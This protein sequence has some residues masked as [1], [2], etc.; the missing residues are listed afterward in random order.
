MYGTYIS[1]VL[2][3]FDEITKLFAIE[4]ELRIIRRRELLP[5]PTISPN[6]S[7]IENKKDKN[8]ILDEVDDELTEMLGIARNIKLAYEKEKEA[9]NKEQQARPAR[10]TNRPEFNTYTVNASTLIKNT[11]TVPQTGTNQHQQTK[12]AVTFDPNPVRH[13]YPMTDP[14]G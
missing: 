14:T 12:V 2:K 10:Q 9:R 11:N 5:I 6:E 13:L 4:N 8:K 3:Q 1:D 7:K